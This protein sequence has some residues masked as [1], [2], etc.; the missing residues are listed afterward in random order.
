MSTALALERLYDK[1]RRRKKLILLSFFLALLVAIVVSISVGVGSPG[2]TQA[3][4][5]ILSRVFSFIEIAP[6]SE[7][8]QLIVFDLRLPRIIIAIIAGAGLAASG[9]TMQ[10]VLRNPLVSSYV[11]GISSASGFGAAV[12]IAFGS[13]LFTEYSSHLILVSAFSFSLLAMFLVYAIA[14]IRGM[15]AET[16]ILAGVAAGYLFSALLSLIQFIIPD[17]EVLDAIV[18]WL[19]GGLTS[20]TWDS[21]L[22]PLCIVSITLVL[23]MRQSWNLNV[24]SLGEEVAKSIGVDSKKVTVT[25][26]LLAT[27][28]TSSIVSFTGVIGFIGLT[29]PHISRV[30]IGGDHRFLL[31]CSAVVGAFLLLCSDTLARLVV[32]PAELPVGIITSL[33]GVPLF[34]YLIFNK[35]R[36]QLG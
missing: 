23:M 28:A 20:I 6:E 8:T 11:L 22:I 35:N 34:L 16:V 2:F 4:N 27:L 36:K 13:I 14:R 33:L 26:M 19:M 21:I 5:V 12:A 7:I 32:M 3:A 31:P 10:G 15:T 18:F 9:A 30:L 1:N 25:C 24:M 17:N 29:S